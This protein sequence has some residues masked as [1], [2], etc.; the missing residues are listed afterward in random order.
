MGPSPRW[1]HSRLQPHIRERTLARCHASRRR[2]PRARAKT[3]VR[4]LPRVGDR[5]IPEGCQSI[6]EVSRISLDVATVD[7]CLEHTDLELFRA[8]TASLNFVKWEQARRSP[9]VSG[10]S[11]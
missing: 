7:L 11:F 10:I 6:Y 3:E 5:V 4:H 8:P 1:H 2:K 9:A